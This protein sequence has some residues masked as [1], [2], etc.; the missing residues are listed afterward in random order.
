M[1][2]HEVLNQPLPREG[3]DEFAANVPLVDAVARWGRGGRTDEA[4]LRTQIAE[5]AEEAR[6]ILGE[7]IG[8]APALAAIEAAYW[9]GFTPEAQSRHAAALA[10]PRFAGAACAAAGRATGTR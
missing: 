1:S 10:Q 4:S 2:T 8:P 3:V 5:R 7:R 9:I 6:K